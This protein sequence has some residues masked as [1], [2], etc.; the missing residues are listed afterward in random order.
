MAGVS[1]G[2]PPINGTTIPVTCLHVVW[3]WS[4][5]LQSGRTDR[6]IDGWTSRRPIQFHVRTFYC[7]LPSSTHPSVR[8][9]AI[10][11]YLVRDRWKQEAPSDWLVLR[12]CIVAAGCNDERASTHTHYPMIVLA[13]FGRDVERLEDSSIRRL[14]LTGMG[15]SR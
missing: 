5:S 13:F 15:W 12:A 6:Q 14:W 3:I 10:A 7:Q 11:L 2:V 1:L 8:S 4:Y 9:R